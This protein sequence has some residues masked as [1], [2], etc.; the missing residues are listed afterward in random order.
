M[1]TITKKQA[2]KLIDNSNL[3][4]GDEII[5]NKIDEYLYEQGLS[6]PDDSKISYGIDCA[7]LFVKDILILN[8]SLPPVSN[9]IVDETKHTRLHLLP[10]EPHSI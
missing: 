2:K 4:P 10:M 8:V 9:Y 3:V 6:F 1:R 5:I 7:G